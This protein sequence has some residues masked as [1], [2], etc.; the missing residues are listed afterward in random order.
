MMET[1]MTGIV[2]MLSRTVHTFLLRCCVAYVAHHFAFTFLNFEIGGEVESSKR[3]K[4]RVSM[5]RFRPRPPVLHRSF[6]RGCGVLLCTDRF[7]MLYGHRQ[8]LVSTLEDFA[9]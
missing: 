7:V 2:Q 9:K 1:R 5:V 6:A 4:I 3:L 8:Q